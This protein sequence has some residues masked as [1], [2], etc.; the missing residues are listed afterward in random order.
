ML[1][2][3]VIINY[4]NASDTIECLESLLN[5]SYIPFNIIIIDNNSLDDSCKKITQWADGNFSLSIAGDLKKISSPPAKKPLA[6]V[7]YHYSDG[8]FSKESENTDKNKSALTIIK[9]AKNLG[10]A[11]A[12]NIGVKFAL[13]HY[14][15]AYF[16]FLNN[17]TVVEKNAL[18]EMIDLS[19]KDKEIGCIGSKIIYYDKPELLQYAG[20]AE[21]ILTHGTTDQKGQPSSNFSEDREIAGYITGTSFLIKK[22]IINRAGLWDENFFLSVEDV[23][24]SERIKKSGYK[25]FFSAKSLVYHKDGSSSK[26]KITIKKFLWTKSERINIKSFYTIGYYDLRNWIYFNKK[27]RLKKLSAKLFYYFLFIPYLFL[28]TIT[29]IIRYD[30]YKLLRIK[31]V[32]KAFIDGFLNRLGFREPLKEFQ[33]IKYE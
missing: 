33:N 21:K 11:G 13:K 18:S 9:S 4:N 15:P 12:N 26:R 30:D 2:S 32:I 20:G 24:Y 3:I 28:G 31:C 27:H 6:Y 8:I 5:L 14:S 29:Y 23:D 10:F 1:V 22:E 25:L 7:M 19:Q 16:W 17:D